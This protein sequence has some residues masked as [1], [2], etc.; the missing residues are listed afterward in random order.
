MA[1][2]LD[3]IKR[4]HKEGLAIWPLVTPVLHEFFDEKQGYTSLRYE[5]LRL[6]R[7]DNYVPCAEVEPQQ[8]HQGKRFGIQFPMY[9]TIHAY[10]KAGNVK[11]AFNLLDTAIPNVWNN[12]L[13]GG[14][15]ILADG[16]VGTGSLA[17]DHGQSLGLFSRAIVEGLFGI[18]P[19]ML[20]GIITITPNFPSTWDHASIKHPLIDYSYINKDNRIVIKL[21]PHK[22]AKVVLDIPVSNIEPLSLTVNGKSG[23]INLKDAL[24]RS[25][26][27]VEIPYSGKETE[28]VLKYKDIDKVKLIY[29]YPAAG[30]EKY[31]VKIKNGQILSI[32]DPQ[33][34]LEKVNIEDDSLSGIISGSKGEHTFFA[35]VK[36]G[37]IS[38]WLPVNLKI[39]EPITTEI[40]LSKENTETAYVAKLI[41]N[42][43]QKIE[44]ALSTNISG[45]ED[46]DQIVLEPHGTVTINHLLSTATIKKL[47]PGKNPV[48]VTIKGDRKYSW[49][50]ELTDYNIF[51]E[52]H[53]V[54][55]DFM[56]NVKVINID[57]LFNDELDN[58]FKH[59]YTKCSVPTYDGIG[60]YD[61]RFPGD[62]AEP[63]YDANYKGPLK[64]GIYGKNKANG[65]NGYDMFNT[66][67]VDKLDDKYIRDKVTDGIY[68]TSIEVPFSQK[69]EG[70]NTAFI[71]L[72]ENFPN[73]IT[74]PD[75]NQKARKIY[76]LLGGTCVTNNTYMPSAEIT[77]NY[78][79]GS[80][81]KVELTHPINYDCI[82]REPFAQEG[83]AESFGPEI[84]INRMDIKM[85]LHVNVLDILT[86]PNKI[87]STLKFKCS[88]IETIVGIM[89]VTL[90]TP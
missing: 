64:Y 22:K 29:S 8:V 23:S 56:K 65:A 82:V 19:D 66:W 13:P 76:L 16:I 80:Q 14:G 20:E 11:E 30:N 48:Y 43:E 57:K 89:G 33:G 36:Q 72:W 10:F 37:S 25:K 47:V 41:N 34:I 71:S 2:Y 69:K 59:K 49:T 62:S 15:A 79:D 73:E 46:T 39:V 63:I 58:L 17:Y 3:V 61:G 90:V 45:Q 21:N 18:E 42:T 1:E 50:S 85:R 55:D 38:Y 86:N 31:T 26:C 54:A 83:I 78:S 77:V 44:G 68:T 12:Y 40:K 6:R 27:V 4:V 84:Y 75:I 51:K 24:L 53:I 35:K 74:V 9:M 81:Q 5:K 70:N 7:P 88:A 28:V 52:Y 32:D 67:Q 60:L 87:I